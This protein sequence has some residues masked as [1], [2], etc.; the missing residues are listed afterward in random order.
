M[1]PSW[2]LAALDTSQQGVPVHMLQRDYL[3]PLPKENTGRGRRG[4]THWT[5]KFLN[6]S[7]GMRIYVAPSLL[8]YGELPSRRSYCISHIKKG[9]SFSPLFCGASAVPGTQELGFHTPDSS[10][11]L[12]TSEPPFCCSP[13]AGI[14]WW[15]R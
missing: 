10:P 1:Q 5:M 8:Q 12:K 6:S 11:R 13:T 7:H 3:P 2:H 9:T 14:K 4:T 15:H